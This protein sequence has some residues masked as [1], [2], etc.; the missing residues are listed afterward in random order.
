MR[1]LLPYVLFATVVL[2]QSPIQPFLAELNRALQNDERAVVAATVQ[3]PVIVMIG[4]IRVP[5]QDARAL[6]ERF[7]EI[8][9]PEL[10]DVVA[11]GAAITETP[12]GFTIGTNALAIARLSGQLKI[13][14]IVVPSVDGDLRSSG[15][16]PARAG[17]PR[18]I[19]LR[20]GPAPTRFA[21][22][23]HSGATDSYLLFVPKGQ[24]LDVR[25]ERVRGE[26]VVRVANAATGAPLN[27]RVAQGALVVSGRAQAGADYRIDVQ[28]TSVGDSALPYMLAVSIR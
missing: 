18:R 15:Q 14:A 3:Y 22:S 28:R 16:S 7:D 13:T 9:T 20:T 10:R 5:F 6:L 23:I 1:R 19:G 2:A 24:L 11:R 21:G 17:E 27:P 12:D 26:A 8:F 4:G 25:L